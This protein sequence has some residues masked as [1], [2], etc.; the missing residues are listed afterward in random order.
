MRETLDDCDMIIDYLN[1]ALG[2]S[3]EEIK[4]SNELYV[5]CIFLHN[6]ISENVEMIK[7]Q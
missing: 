6:D 3:A 2:K 1:N 7:I 5:K 4:M